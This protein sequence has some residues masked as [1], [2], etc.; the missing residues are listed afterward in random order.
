MHDWNWLLL[1]RKNNLYDKLICLLVIAYHE[2]YRCYANILS[3]KQSLRIFQ[4]FSKH[5]FPRASNII[6]SY[7]QIHKTAQVTVFHSNLSHRKTIPY[8]CDL[9]L[10]LKPWLLAKMQISYSHLFDMTVL[11]HF[12]GPLILCFLKPWITWPKSIY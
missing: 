12:W 7:A 10:Y 3:L 5:F 9:L 6:S 4:L 1:T 11:K 2:E 8:F